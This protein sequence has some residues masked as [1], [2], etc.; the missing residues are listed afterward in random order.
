[1]RIW[2]KIDFWSRWL[3]LPVRGVQQLVVEQAPEQYSRY[4]LRIECVAFCASHAAHANVGAVPALQHFRSVTCMDD[5]LMILLLVSPNCV[6]R[7]ASPEAALSWHVCTCL[8]C[9]AP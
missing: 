9:S 4:M 7:T 8:T 6:C 2:V 3:L 5:P 1:M